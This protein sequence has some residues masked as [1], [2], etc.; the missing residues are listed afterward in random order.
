MNKEFARS[1]I[2]SHK[3]QLIYKHFK[4]KLKGMC[5]FDKK[6]KCSK[7]C[8]QWEIFCECRALTVR[9][10]LDLRIIY[11]AALRDGAPAWKKSSIRNHHGPLR[12]RQLMECWGWEQ[13]YHSKI[14][15]DCKIGEEDFCSINGIWN[16]NCEQPKGDIQ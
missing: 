13:I 12:I 5:P 7:K 14:C 9:E 6:K 4:K 8:A 11:E 16:K 10:I 2:D 15:F 1:M 3:I